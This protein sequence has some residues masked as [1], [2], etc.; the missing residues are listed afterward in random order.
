[1]ANNIYTSAIVKIKEILETVDELQ[2]VFAHPLGKDFRF[3]KYPAV[4]FTPTRLTADFSDTSSNH[5][6][7]SF[8]LWVIVSSNNQK[9]DD[10]FERILPKT[11]DAVVGA[12]G[13]GWDFGTIEG[14]RTWARMESGDMGYTQG[15]KGLEAWMELNLIVRLDAEI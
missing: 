1:M 2:E 3:T 6:V 9:V 8:K 12:F 15:Q 11:V 10:I 5:H 14:H 4:V 13:T 7:M